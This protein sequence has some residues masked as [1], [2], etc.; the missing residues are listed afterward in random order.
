MDL[1]VSSLI[2]GKQCPFCA[3]G[4]HCLGPNCLG[5]SGKLRKYYSLQR[6]IYNDETFTELP[7]SSQAYGGV[8]SSDIP[9]LHFVEETESK[10]S[11]WCV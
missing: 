5:H 3:D 2:A 4:G 9:G 7:T 1:D 11:N 8:S 10:E 6:V